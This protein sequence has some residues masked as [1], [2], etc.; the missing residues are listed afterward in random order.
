MRIIVTSEGKK[1]GVILSDHIQFDGFIPH[2]NLLAYC[3]SQGLARVEPESYSEMSV[4]N[5][6]VDKYIKL[7]N[8]LT[9]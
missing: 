6:F 7:Q 4:V 1:L 5:L 9:H 3:V 2:M 8:P